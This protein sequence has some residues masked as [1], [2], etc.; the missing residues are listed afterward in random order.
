MPQTS[1]HQLLDA[2]EASPD[3]RALTHR[4]A[5]LPA[6]PRDDFVRLVRA[7]TK[8]NLETRLW[9]LRIARNEPFL[10]AA[11]SRF[12]AERASLHSPLAGAISSVG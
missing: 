4:I 1:H 11:R 7:D 5:R 6:E 9:V 2:L 3:L 10:D 12:G 8:L